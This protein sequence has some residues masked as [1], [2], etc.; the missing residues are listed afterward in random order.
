LEDSQSALDGVKARIDEGDSV[1]DSK[2]GE[3][4]KKP[5]SAKDLASITTSS[6]DKRQLLRGKPTSRTET[7]SEG[8][9]LEQLAAQFIKMAQGAKEPRVIQGE[10]IENAVNIP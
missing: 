9:R 5:I 1:Y 4:V 7:V 6:I 8:K 2:R 10:V 3:L